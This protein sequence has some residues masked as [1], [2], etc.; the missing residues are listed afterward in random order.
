MV[1]LSWT[2][3]ININF[4]A[5]PPHVTTA[6]C[7]PWAGGG[8]PFQG[9]LNPD[10]LIPCSVVCLSCWPANMQK[11]SILLV[12]KSKH[13]RN[14]NDQYIEGTKNWSFSCSPGANALKSSWDIY[15]FHILWSNNSSSRNWSKEIIRGG[16]R[17]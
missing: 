2:H 6:K 10:F 16:K 4:L 5:S 1:S 17:I 9:P 3:S 8:P 14:D 7:K 11:R 12:L 15:F 13:Q